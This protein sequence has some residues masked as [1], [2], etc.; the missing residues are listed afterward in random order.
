MLEAP[1]RTTDVALGNTASTHVGL[2]LDPQLLPRA[3]PTAASTIIN[4]PN[5]TELLFFDF[6]GALVLASLFVR[7]FAGGSSWSSPWSS[8]SSDVG[9]GATRTA[10][11]RG[12]FLDDL[13]P[14]FAP[15]FFV[16]SDT[17]A[18]SASGEGVDVNGVA[19]AT[20][21]AG[22]SPAPLPSPSVSN[23]GNAGS[24]KLGSGS[25]PAPLGVADARDR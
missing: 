11:G 6:A 17:S 3:T 13:A 8:A 20:V 2:G 22:C 16:F 21:I 4:K 9:S 14:V 23:D 10:S 18:A 7:R 15:F 25:A 5:P 1:P 24:A 19:S 12:V